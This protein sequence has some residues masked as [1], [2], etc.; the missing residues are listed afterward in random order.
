MILPTN[1]NLSPLDVVIRIKNSFEE[2]VFSSHLFYNSGDLIEIM[3]DVMNNGK[4]DITHLFISHMLRDAVMYI[5]NTLTT[6]TGE[7]DILFRIIRWR[8]VTL[9]SGELAALSFQ[10]RVSNQQK[11]AIPFGASYTYRKQNQNCGT[12]K[13]IGAI[14]EKRNQ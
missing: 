11:I 7:A 12:Y 10:A 2:N 14:L 3:I 5:P 4:E 13:A 6:D 1:M 8:I 9:K